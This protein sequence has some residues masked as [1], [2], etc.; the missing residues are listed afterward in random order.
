M[1][2]DFLRNFAEERRWIQGRII[3]VVCLAFVIAAVLVGRM[4]TLQLFEYD[5]YAARSQ[6]NRIRLAPIDPPR[7]N[8]TDRRGKVLAENRPAFNLIIVPEQVS[9]INSLLR[10]LS[11]IVEL[12]PKDL[13]RFQQA[14]T[15][16]R[17][18]QEIALK[19][20]LTDIEVARLANDRHRFPGVEVQPR[21]TRHYPF[22]GSASHVIGY[23]SR[24]NEQELRDSDR[25]RYRNASIVGK[26]GIEKAYE[27]R[28]QGYLGIAQI[29]TNATGRPLQVLHQDHPQSGEDIQL[30]LDMELQQAAEAAL[31]NWRGAV[32]ALEPQTGAILALVSQPVFNPNQ[33]VAGLDQDTFQALANAP[34][35]PLF[36]RAISGRYPPGSVTK[37]FLGLAGLATENFGIHETLNCTGVYN[38]PNVSRTWRDWRPGGH[39]RIGFTQ[40]VAQSCDIYF[41]ELAH[42]MGIDLM[43]E[44]MTQFGFGQATGIDLP[45]ERPGVMP[46]TEWKQN[47]LGEAWFPGETLNVGI[48]QGF[49]LSTPLQLAST[50]AM[51]ANR[52]RPIRPHLLLSDNSEP[53]APELESLTLK[54]ERLWQLAIDSMVETVHGRL[55]TARAVGADLPYKIAGKT[56]TAQ[57][58]GLGPDEEY[59]EEAIEERFRDHA[60]FIAFAPADN[61]QIAVAVLVENGGS[62]SAT[63]A[64]IGASVINTW[65]TDLEGWDELSLQSD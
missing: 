35:Q 57:V 21:L 2:L 65:L 26:T 64:P 49:M 56:G 58:I 55:G 54:D 62:G 43:H 37:P 63:A 8:I 59:D 25:T 17:S 38:L 6:D 18:F 41:Y 36:N 30:T 12:T 28:L 60:V 20:D 16:S 27:D 23:V 14:R 11:A 10:Q 32:V 15:S 45:S 3:L 29:E 5:R 4:A 7:G 50:T 46:S 40:S 44:W 47:R 39:G 22:G 31:G 51:M 48:G 34:G 42:R 9:D 53:P 61:P 1:K 13:A 33:M 24:I 19:F 52:G